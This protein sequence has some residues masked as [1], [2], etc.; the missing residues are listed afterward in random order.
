MNPW[1]PE[2]VT[3]TSLHYI[4]L[5]YIICQLRS[6]PEEK[7]TTYAAW[8]IRSRDEPNS[9]EPH[10]LLVIA[11]SSSLPLKN[12]GIIWGSLSNRKK[13]LCYL[14]GKQHWL[15]RN[16][17]MI[18]VRVTIPTSGSP[19]RGKKSKRRCPKYVKCN[20]KICDRYRNIY[21]YIYIYI[22]ILI[23]I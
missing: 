19:S 20:T 16:T 23:Y 21:I 10:E 12:W 13:G 6:S 17:Q 8:Q 15:W 22:Y 18:S 3:V 2:D 1:T 9:H 14:K 7:M 4:T 5:H 11:S